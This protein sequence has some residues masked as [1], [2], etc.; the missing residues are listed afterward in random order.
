MGVTGGELTQ[1]KITKA[2]MKASVE[3]GDESKEVVS[4]RRLQKIRNC[5][6]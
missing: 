5:C 6:L 3:S 4:G 1:I 2:D